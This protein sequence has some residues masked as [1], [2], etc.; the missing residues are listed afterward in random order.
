MPILQ[1]KYTSEAQ[2][3]RQ[4]KTILEK[5]EC[6]ES[7]L[8][9]LGSL[10]RLRRNLRGLPSVST[11]VLVVQPTKP[12]SDVSPRSTTSTSFGRGPVPD[13][14]LFEGQPELVIDE[15]EIDEE[16]AAI[17]AG[18]G[19]FLGGGVTKTAADDPIAQTEKTV[20]VRPGEFVRGTIVPFD[21][22]AA[23]FIQPP[24]TTPQSGLL[25]QIV[26]A[27]SRG[28]ARALDLETET[29]TAQLARDATQRRRRF[30]SE[31]EIHVD[32]F[33]PFLGIQTIAP[34]IIKQIKSESDELLLQRNVGILQQQLASTIRSEALQPD[35]S[36]TKAGERR[37]GNFEQIRARI[38]GN[39]E[40]LRIEAMGDE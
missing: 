37:A 3:C 13:A 5:L 6:S 1:V 26:M 31:Q 7:S 11:T 12:P 36:G 34:T 9:G 27:A 22:F 8:A 40:I 29:I 39:L 30:V 32:L 24:K 17:A 33:T 10:K 25:G 15:P 28:L 4:L 19:L 35:L 38:E 14:S 23:P 21:D 2:L 18:P 16:E 20:E